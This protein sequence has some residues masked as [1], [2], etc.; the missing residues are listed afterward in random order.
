MLGDVID[1]ENIFPTQAYKQDVD[2]DDAMDLAVDEFEDFIH[3]FRGRNAR[4]KEINMWTVE[5]NHGRVGRRNS[6]KTN[7]DRIFY[8]RLAD[9]LN[10]KNTNVNISKKWYNYAEIQG[11]GYLMFHGEDIMMYQTIPYYGIVQRAMR[12]KSGGIH[13]SYFN[14]VC[15]GHFH[16]V[17][18]QFWNDFRVLLNGTFVT[19]D[20]FV[21]KKL[22]M[23]EIPKFWFFGVNEERPMTWTY[24]LELTR[25][26]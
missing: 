18:D 25:L 24:L 7:F 5:G 20:D 19:D 4:F 8:K 6:E 11:H 23:K 17:G 2:A 14:Y 3:S 22:G 12:W 26:G 21:Q 16:T 10:G 1:G 9:R 13:E 15:L